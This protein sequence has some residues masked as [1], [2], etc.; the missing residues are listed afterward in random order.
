MFMRET[1]KELPNSAISL[2][3]DLAVL[4]ASQ[5]NEIERNVSLCENF[6]ANLINDVFANKLVLL[7]CEPIGSWF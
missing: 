7:R 5:S 3:D 1:N 2:E 4:Q 6:E